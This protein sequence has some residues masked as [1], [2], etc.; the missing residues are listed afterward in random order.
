MTAQDSLT[1]QIV[2]ALVAAGVPY[3][4]SGSFAS[5]F[6]GIPRSTKDADFVIRQSG[7]VGSGFSQQLGADFELDPQLSF[8]TV[9]GTYK[10]LVRQRKGPFKI[11][12]FLLSQD[13]HDQSR[14]ARRREEVLFGR[15]VWLLSPE[16]CVISKLR[17]ARNKDEDD[18]RNVISV[19]HSNLDWPYIE[20]WCIAHGTLALLD[21][22]R[23]SVPDI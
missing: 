16:D 11:E 17:W 3:F 21:E 13:P 6:Y 20:K 5:N 14:F 15:K 4:L 7:G 2:D 22:I 23:G 1:L 12:I 8:E 18:V 19:Q 10:Q 9:T